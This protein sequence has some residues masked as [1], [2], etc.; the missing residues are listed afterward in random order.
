VYVDGFNLYFGCLKGTPY[1][2]LDVRALSAGLLREISP[3][4]RIGRVRYFTARI[5]QQDADSGPVR[6]QRAYL[7]A[8]QSLNNLTIHYGTFKTNRKSY[9]LADG[10]GFAEIVRSEE[11]GSDVNL[12]SYLIFDALDAEMDIALVVS[13]DTD[14]LHPLEMVQA[15]F[16]LGIGIAAPCYLRGRY[17]M[18]ELEASA[19]FTAHILRRHKQLLVAAQLPPVVHLGDGRVVMR[20]EAWR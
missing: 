8:L 11:K 17:P 6:R 18:R 16:G 5:H 14:L 13:N 9:P 4:Y 7:R 12:A 3:R 1:K 15:R 20:P 2:W 10:S 19:D